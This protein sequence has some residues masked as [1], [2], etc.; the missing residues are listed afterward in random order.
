MNR[1]VRIGGRSLAVEWTRVG[2]RVTFRVDGEGRRDI[3]ILE[4]EPG[5]YSVLLGS[6]SFEARVSALDGGYFVDIRGRHIYV[7]VIDPRESAFGS[8]AGEGEGRISVKAPMPGRVVRLLVNAGEEVCAGQGLIVVE[9]M[10]MQNELRSPKA[11]RVISMD[12]REAQAVGAGQVL[13][14]V[15]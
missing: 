14:V 7:Q 8:R 3:S 9:A 5:V 13:A 10:K 1:I 12:V 15:E 11:G 4:I 6:R 2:D